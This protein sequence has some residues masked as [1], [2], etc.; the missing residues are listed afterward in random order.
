MFQREDDHNQDEGRKRKKERKHTEKLAMKRV[1]L[2]MGGPPDIRGVNLPVM[3]RLAK[4]NAFILPT[5]R[6]MQSYSR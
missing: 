6:G 2:R 4:S 1:V 5:E 3:S